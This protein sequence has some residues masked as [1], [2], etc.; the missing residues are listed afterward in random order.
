MQGTLRALPSISG[1][2]I[3]FIDQMIRDKYIPYQNPPDAP[4]K[5]EEELETL[6]RQFFPWTSYSTQLAKCVYDWTTASFIRLVFLKIFEYTDL[7]PE[8]LL[9]LDQNSIATKI[10]ES[11]WSSYTPQDRDYMH[12]FMMRP[13]DSLNEVKQQLNDVVRGLH[14]LSD[15][16]NRLL[17]MA[18]PSLPRVSA[19]QRPTLY[20]GQVDIH[21]LGL[22][23]FGIEFLECYLN[24]GPVGTEL[25]MNIDDVLGNIVATGRPIT[26]KMAWSFTDN[27]GDAMHYSNGILL[28]A[29][30]YENYEVN[31]A[32]WDRLADITPLSDDPNKTEYLFIPGTRFD[33]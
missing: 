32:A 16:E 12:S 3:A 8:P 9:P 18:I 25:V 7:P 19:T 28:I 4:G 15:V 17:S 6:G 11:S 23:H 13:A 21:Q 27:L 14:R 1:D 26:T 22:E 31:Y 10:W 33:V 20:S 24:R 5:A 29:L 30:A 2:D